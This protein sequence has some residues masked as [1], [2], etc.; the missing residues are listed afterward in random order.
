ML[1]IA[2][3][4]PVRSSED[5]TDDSLFARIA[6]DI[7][8]RGFSIQ[9]SALP[10]ELT[11][12]LTQYLLDTNE[13]NF[14]RGGIGRGDDYVHSDFVRTDEI[15]WIT[16]NTEAGRQWVQW[17]GKLQAFLNRRLFLGLFSFESH[18]A[19]YQQGDFYKRH[20]D[21][22]KGETNRII[23]LVVYLNSGWEPYDGGELVLYQNAEDATGTKVTPLMGT[24]VAFLSEDFPHEVLPSGRDRF[25][26]AGWFRVNSSL[27]GRIDPPS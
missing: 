8:N 4:L 17:T 27:Q 16:E 2:P 3:L 26:I 23:S 18:F 20:L 15:C 10:I 5:F 24:I 9:P 7:E 6:D 25:S 1:M 14:E 13:L 12:I 22:F 21:A 11:N 19:H